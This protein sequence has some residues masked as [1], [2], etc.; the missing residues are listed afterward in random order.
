VSSPTGK[1]PAFEAGDR[2]STP[3]T[4]ATY[5]L[6]WRVKARLPERLGQACRVLVR[7]HRLNSVLVEFKDGTKVVT[8]GYYVWPRHKLKVAKIG[9]ETPDLFE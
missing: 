9:H 8:S 6:V 5:D 3:C 1:T 2:G 7:S 4:G